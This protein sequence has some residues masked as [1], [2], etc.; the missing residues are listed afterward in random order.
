MVRVLAVWVVERDVQGLIGTQRVE[1]IRRRGG[2][3]ECEG[4]RWRRGLRG[5]ERR[6]AGVYIVESSHVPEIDEI[7]SE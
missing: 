4:D 1:M 2:G 7:K 6:A 3:I 5:G